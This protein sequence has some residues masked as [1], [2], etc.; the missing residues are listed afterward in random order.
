M[1]H[2]GELHRGYYS[3]PALMHYRGVHHP[4]TMCS[5]AAATDFIAFG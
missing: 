5:Q 2:A 4:L 1:K 3:Y